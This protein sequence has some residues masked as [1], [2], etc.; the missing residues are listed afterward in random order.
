MGADYRVASVKV[1]SRKNEHGEW[2]V[3][4]RDCRGRVIATYFTDDKADAVGTA[5]AMMPAEDVVAEYRIAGHHLT[6][7]QVR[8]ENVLCYRVRDAAARGAFDYTPEQA[9]TVLA[10]WGYTPEQRRGAL[11]AYHAANSG[12][13]DAV[14]RQGREWPANERD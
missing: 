7:A 1:S 11:A 3:R 4:A 6:M 13:A 8:A 9:Q 14:N 12:L 2:V 10:G 5:K